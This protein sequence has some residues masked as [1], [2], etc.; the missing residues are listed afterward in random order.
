MSSD[1][2]KTGR[3][4]MDEIH[5]ELIC[6]EDW[7]EYAAKI[8]KAKTREELLDVFHEIHE[9]YNVA[10][11]DAVF[12]FSKVFL[13]KDKFFELLVEREAFLTDCFYR[14]LFESNQE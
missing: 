5:P 1:T 14:K 13:S 12:I 4:K 10:I 9:K 3:V 7:V 11:G 2:M 8:P 6:G